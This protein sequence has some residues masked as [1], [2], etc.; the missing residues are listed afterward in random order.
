VILLDAA[1]RVLPAMSAPS[2]TRALA[3]LE[4]MGVEVRLSAR[5][6]NVDD[7]GVCIGDERLAAENV[8]WAAGVQASPLARSLGVA[9]GSGGRVIVQSDLSIPGYPETFVA[10]DL[11][12]ATCAKTG[13]AVPGMC[14]GA[15]QMGE[16]IAGMIQAAIA[17]PVIAR[18]ASQ[19]PFVFRDK[20]QM[21]T[22]GRRRAVA[23]VK[24]RTFSGTL[25]WV[26]WC[27]V[28]I[29][30]LIGFRRRLFVMLSWGWNYIAWSKGAR[31]IT[32]NPPV[33]LTQPRRT[34]SHAGD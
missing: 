28:H 31:L 34:Q 10:G 14:P 5:V 3:D 19:K 26:L 9:L 13:Q 30:F 11:A 33:R 20:G 23:D 27:F 25:A 12:L 15:M 4:T 2:S 7:D 22:I 32:G 21:A 18:P 24:H 8:F 1:D 16:H 29:Y 17:C 6:T